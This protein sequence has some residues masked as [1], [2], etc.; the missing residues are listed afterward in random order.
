MPFPGDQNTDKSIISNSEVVNQSVYS[1]CVCVCVCVCVF[2]S[3][4]VCDNRCKSGRNRFKLAN[5]H[6][7]YGHIQR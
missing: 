1:V 7:G 2:V 6:L 3:V 4:C 5:L